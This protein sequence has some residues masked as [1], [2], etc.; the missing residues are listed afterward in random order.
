MSSTAAATQAVKRMLSKEFPRIKPITLY[1]IYTKSISFRQ[2]TVARQGKHFEKEICELLRKHR[3]AFKCQVRIDDRGVICTTRRQNHIIDIVVGKN[4]L[5]GQSITK[6]KVISCKKSCR[7]RWNQDNW[8][9]KFPPKK[10]VLVT[11]SKDYPLS[12]R[13]KESRRR[14]IVAGSQKLNDDRKFKLAIPDIVSELL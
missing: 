10:Y 6:F 1:K 12:K 4:I 8:T 3:I 5:P 13:F 9:F 11:Q 2:S 14:K 7:E